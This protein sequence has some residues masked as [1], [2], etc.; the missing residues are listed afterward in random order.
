MYCYFPA[1]W[2]VNFVQ[3]SPVT[4]VALVVFTLEP[5]YA[6]KYF[7]KVNFKFFK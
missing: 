1:I 4:V 2:L 7:K 5:K 6:K 3:V